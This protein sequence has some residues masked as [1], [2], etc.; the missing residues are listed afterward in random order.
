[1]YSFRA[2]TDAQCV[3]ITKILIIYFNTLNTYCE[4][5]YGSLVARK[6]NV[7]VNFE[8]HVE[9]LTRNRVTFF[10]FSNP[11]LLIRYSKTLDKIRVKFLKC[12]SSNLFKIRAL[13]RC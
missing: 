11:I 6:Q 2:I 12:V 13:F 7:I 4:L 8:F 10:A 5:V 9:L 1:M 3:L